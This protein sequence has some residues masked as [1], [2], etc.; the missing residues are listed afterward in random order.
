M[1][2]YATIMVLLNCM[3]SFHVVMTFERACSHESA[4]KREQLHII[5]L[6]KS[7]SQ[8]HHLAQQRVLKSAC[9]KSVMCRS[10][11]ISARSLISKLWSHGN[12]SQ[13]FVCSLGIWHMHPMWRSQSTHISLQHILSSEPPCRA[14]E[15]CWSCCLLPWSPATQGIGCN[16]LHAE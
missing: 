2:R 16:Q 9:C 14:D 3:Q 5:D 13:G 15:R 4:I 11:R 8:S 7:K 6:K 12:L 1:Q 10:T